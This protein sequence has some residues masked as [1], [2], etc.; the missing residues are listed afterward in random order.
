[1]LHWFEIQADRQTDTY[2]LTTTL[3]YIALLKLFCCSKKT[4]EEQLLSRFGDNSRSLNC[5]IKCCLLLFVCLL[6]FTSPSPHPHNLCASGTFYFG[7][8]SHSHPHRRSISLHAST[9]FRTVIV[10][11][12]ITKFVTVS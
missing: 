3:Y 8:Y 7:S 1:M 4:K 9:S 12:T 2:T 6:S 10:A 5:D 11:A